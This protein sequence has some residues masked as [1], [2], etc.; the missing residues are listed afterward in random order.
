MGAMFTLERLA[1]VDE[2]QAVNAKLMQAVAPPPIHEPVR[3]LATSS[4]VKMTVRASVK[5]G[6]A[7]LGLRCDLDADL[8]QG[9]GDENA[10]IATDF[11]QALAVDLAVGK[12][13]VFDAFLLERVRQML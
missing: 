6:D 4:G 1:R 3:T 2:A 12:A 13:R 11:L 8:H 9:S 5:D 7:H 10:S